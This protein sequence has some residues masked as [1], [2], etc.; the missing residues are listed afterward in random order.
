MKSHGRELSGIE[1]WGGVECTIN[2]V[3]D[4]YFEQLDRTGHP[5]R[6][7]DLDRFAALEIKAIRQ[8]V[9]WERVAP[10]ENAAPDWTW[11]DAAL[12][13]LR[14]LNIRPIAGL[15]HHGSGPPHTSL[16]DEQFPEKLAA[17]ARR[18]AERY[19]WVQDYTPVN[20]PLTTAR[21]SGLYG[22]WYPHHRDDLSFLRALLTQ[23]RAIVLAMKAIRE[24][25]PNA[26]LIQTEDLG[27]IFSTPAMAYQASF[28]NERRWCSY[29]LLFGRITRSHPMWD[30]M[31]WVGISENELSW[32]LDEPC[33]PSI[34]GINHYL[35]SDRFLDEQVEFYPHYTHGSNGR[36][37]YADV[38]ARRVRESSD[39]SVGSLLEETSQRY[40]LPVA[41]TECHNGC[42]REEQ[43]R[44]FLDVWRE[45]QS[46]R[47][48][49][50]DVVAITAWSLLGAFDW[51]HLVTR[52]EGHYEPG[53]FD[54]RSNPPRPTAMATL[55]RGLAANNDPLHPL[56]EVPGWWK[57]ASRFA[58][59][60]S[61][62]PAGEKRRKD[63]TDPGISAEFDSVR[64]I[65]ITGAHGAL[66]G[67]FAR[68]CEQRGIPYCALSRSEL[69]I[70]DPLKL[71]HALFQHRPWAVIN[72][73]EYSPGEENGEDFQRCYR[74]N[75]EG[76]TLLAQE[77]ARYNIDLLTFSSDLVF[78]GR[79]CRPYLE[80]DRVSPLNSYGVSK[81]LA[82]K[83]VLELLP[84]ALVVRT[85]PLFGPWNEDNFVT[86]ALRDLMAERKLQSADNK[87]ISPTYIPDL[88]NSCLDLVIDGECGI[89]HMANPGEISLAEM[90]K[91]TAQALNVDAHFLA[92]Q[93]SSDLRGPA[94][95]AAYR[96]LHS[97]R[98]TLLPSLEDAIMRYSAEIERKLEIP[99]L[100][101]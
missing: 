55:I 78:D 58:Y 52:K 5:W 84:A 101:A 6:V 75:T 28:E 50:V 81:A 2:R 74:D 9:L 69:D 95:R 40:Q 90:I 83:R 98:G 26:R 41:I 60:I 35:S 66:A 45:A 72:T 13:H 14:N 1:I 96:V 93:K 79:S 24:I 68:I 25:N 85:G 91:K 67:A 53:V 21:F 71:R 33:P 31:T 18:V 86:S 17:Y 63:V 48:K 65:L 46:A 37:Q 51:N 39:R 43:L 11:T 59:G 12:S 64:P 77:C 82:E 34:L 80:A 36:V 92:P 70:A 56:L 54:I 62:S 3:G 20:E 32:F 23:C 89:W 100:A 57:R 15:V 99:V 10:V 97:Q 88:V 44:W 16:L 8:P 30:Y 19:P 94:R 22:H 73:S 49:G 76:P 7:S 27:T 42:T 87:L 47:S 29:D 61:V 38:L 4:A